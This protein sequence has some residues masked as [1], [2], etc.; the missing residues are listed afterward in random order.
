VSTAVTTTSTPVT[1][2]P[3]T[4]A[5]AT[6]T[7]ATTAP[8]GA[9][10]GGAGPIVPGIYT[11]ESKYTSSCT[12]SPFVRAKPCGANT[13]DR[14]VLDGS[15][16]SS[17]SHW[18]FEATSAAPD[19]YKI[20]NMGDGR[21]TCGN[22]MGAKGV[23]CNFDG[24]DHG[25]VNS[26]DPGLWKILPGSVDSVKLLN[27]E[28]SLASGCGAYLRRIPCDKTNAN[29]VKFSTTNSDTDDIRWKLTKVG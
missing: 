14:L 7:H 17:F 27:V 1:T 10:I 21:S 23:R 15:A 9:I 19:I 24:M 5:P 20:T 13:D 22:V 4:T 8:V 18:K 12:A 16:S 3:A 11:I 25:T 28:R 6:T 26:T 2:A 29:V